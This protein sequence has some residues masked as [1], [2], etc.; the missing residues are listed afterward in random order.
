MLSLL[1]KKKWKV[2]CGKKMIRLLNLTIRNFRGFGASVDSVAL[3][4][5]LILLY[6]PNGYGKTSF[7]EAIEWL[8]YGTTKRRQRGEEFSKSEYVGTF[9][10]AHG[11]TP[12]E[13]EL[14]VLL[15]GRQLTLRATQSKARLRL[16]VMEGTLW[17]GCR[18]V[19][20]AS[21]VPVEP[22][23]MRGC[24]PGGCHCLS[25]HK[26]HAPEFSPAAEK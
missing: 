26:R 23:M 15:D 16:A 2:P 9:A 19:L 12:T 11:G 6:G 14:Q 7:A 1:L 24:W 13:V 17:G 10:N 22:G 25:G 20:T 8:F 18:S 21:A 4:G 5:D 3:D